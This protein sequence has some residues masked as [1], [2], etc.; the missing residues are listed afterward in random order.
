MARAGLPIPGGFHVT[1]EA[2]RR[3]VSEFRDEID[4]GDPEGT[5]ELFARHD[6]PS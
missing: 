3:H 2:Y 5:K 6:I 4:P 1:T